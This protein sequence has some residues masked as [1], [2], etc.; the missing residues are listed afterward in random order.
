[1]YSAFYVK[2]VI[3]KG[4]FVIF[5]VYMESL[6]ANAI[7]AMVPTMEFTLPY[8]GMVDVTKYIVAAGIFFALVVLFKVIQVVIIGR[9]HALSKRTSTDVDDVIIE[10]VK[11]IRSWVYVL[12]AL[13]IALQLFTLPDVASKLLSG[14]VYFAI[15]WQA[16]EIALCF[17]DY[18]STR[19]LEKDEDGDGIIDPGSTTASHMVTL[20]ARIVLWALGV[21]FVLSNMG[22]E[23]TSLIAGLGI[24]GIAVA[25]ALQGVLSDLFAS[26]SIYLDKP[27]RIGD[28]IVLGAD[29]GV[30]ERI[31]IK[32]TRI[33]TLQ[34]EE[35]VVS[36]AELTAA[37]V[38][39]FKKMKERR[40]AMQ[41]GVTYETAHDK[42]K[43]IN[44]IVTRIFGSIEGARLDRVHFTTFADSALLFD[45]VFYVD[46]PEYA[47]FLDRQ[48]QFNFELMDKFA[49]VGID[50]AYPTQTLYTK[51]IN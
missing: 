23:V 31:G 46:S 18:G 30:V 42:V 26:F 28:Y 19:F 41:F 7:A 16:I 25:F 34:G 48:Q 43:Q 4:L 45:V 40:T 8:F 14:I 27:F 12:V 50:F 49:E 17:I 6:S 10:A 24:G 32:T 47:D 1:V 15:V 22:I 44:G 5:F 3:I 29:S 21:I 33:R 20:M 13:F 51:T 11:G 39:N 9:L 35:L 37:R 2:V 36:N 38:Q